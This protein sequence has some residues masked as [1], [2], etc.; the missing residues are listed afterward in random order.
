MEFLENAWY[1]AGWSHE[2]RC[3]KL[4]S[5]T[6]LNRALVLFRDL[7]G[8]ARALHDQCP[9]RFAP[10]SLGE[11]RADGTVRC[12]YHGLVFDG[13]GRCV[14]NPHGDGRVP[15]A[16]AVRSY[17]L[18]ERH[19]I[20][21]V[22]MG[23]PQE[24]DVSTLPDYGAIDESLCHV[25]RRYLHVRA[26]Y[27]LESDNILDLSHVQFLHPGTLGSSAMATG[28]TEVEQSGHTVTYKRTVRG[29]ALMPFLRSNFHI[30]EGEL[31]DRWLQVRWDP[32]SSLLQTVTIARSGRPAAEGRSILI[33]HLFSPETASTTHYWFASCFSRA[34]HPDGA[35]RAERHA[36]GLHVPFSTEDMPMLEA[37]QRRMGQRDFWSLKPILLPSDAAAVRARRVLEGLMRTAAGRAASSTPQP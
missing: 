5:R 13:N 22:W 27:Q 29:E 19:G 37:Q 6:L 12:Q 28:T 24:A 20:A 25:A 36:T 16:A 23:P 3:D 15:Q 7:Q 34:D 32:P 14:Q 30:P 17:P 2:L 18:T 33:P 11:I 9:H 26:N 1:M 8:T 10:L 31:A 4:L 21:W 35:E